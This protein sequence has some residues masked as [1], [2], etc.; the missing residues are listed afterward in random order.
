MRR[1]ARPWWISAILLIAQ[2]ALGLGPE[3]R[4]RLTALLTLDE[5]RVL[6]V[7]EGEAAAAV[8]G[9]IDATMRLVAQL[10]DPSALALRQSLERAARAELLP[11][12]IDAAEL[13][14][15]VDEKLAPGEIAQLAHAYALEARFERVARRFDARGD[16]FEEHAA[17]ARR[18]GVES[19]R[20]FLSRIGDAGRGDPAEPLQSPPAEAETPQEAE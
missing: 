7:A 6:A 11:L 9:E 15:I 3:E 20:R 10:D 1:F 14:R 12:D 18:R 16:G 13:Q 8:R 4:D 19:R 2:P 5:Q 17:R